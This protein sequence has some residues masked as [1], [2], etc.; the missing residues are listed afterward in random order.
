MRPEEL[1]GGRSRISGAKEGTGIERPEEFRGT[2]PRI[3]G[4]N[5]DDPFEGRIFIWAWTQWFERIEGEQGNVD[6]TPVA[7][8]EPELR[9]WLER[10]G[11][12]D[13]MELTGEDSLTVYQEF[14]DQVPLYPEA[15]E[16]S[17]ESLFREQ[18]PDEDV[19]HG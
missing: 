18:H 14:L 7:D 13:I 2:R 12:P 9:H 19:E 17:V 10:Q 1:R 11:E 3:F 6:F 8:S 4:T 16:L 15:P 5:Q